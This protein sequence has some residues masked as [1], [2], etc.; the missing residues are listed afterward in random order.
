L[1]TSI[2]ERG[3]FVSRDG[4]ASWEHISSGL[5]ANGSHHKVVFDP[6]NAQV[7]Y[8]T[9]AFSG[10]Y[11]SMD[12]ALTWM[13]IN[14]GLDSRAVT[15]LAVS[16]DGQHVYVGTNGAGVYRLDLNGQPPVAKTQPGATA[17]EP[18]ALATP[19]A[20]EAEA[21]TPSASAADTPGLGLYLG[22][23]AGVVILGV[24][25]LILARRRHG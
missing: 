24:L 12:G 19:A 1:L 2:H 11:R 7:V 20:A 13:Q 25:A 4:G 14:D 15:G 6:T 8:T 5:E 21:P 10:V 16:G 17:T 18:P 9:D 23:G 3:F 22:L